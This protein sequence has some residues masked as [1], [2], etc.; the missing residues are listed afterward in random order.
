MNEHLWT[1][2]HP[3]IL[4]DQDLDVISDEGAQIYKVLRE[5]EIPHVVIMGVHTN[6]CILNR[7]F[8]IKQLVR[9]GVDTMLC[10]DLT[11][12]MYNPTTSPYVDRDTG[13][14]LVLVYIESHW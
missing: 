3:A 4:I 13:T 2:Q 12:S 5:R 6:M 11:D 8:G 7:S 1:R 9:W 14:E 10:R